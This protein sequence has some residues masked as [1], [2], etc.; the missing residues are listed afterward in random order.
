M[1]DNKLIDDLNSDNIPIFNVSEITNEIRD[2]LEN[3]YPYVKIKGEISGVTQAKSGHVYLKLKDEKNNIKGVIWAGIL[4]DLLIQPKD[5]DEVICSGRITTYTGYT[6]E[7]QLNIESIAYEGEGQLLKKKEEIK[8]KLEKEGLFDDKYKKEIPFIPKLLGIITSKSGAVLYEMEKIINE[9]FSV[10]RR[11]YPVTVQGKAAVREIVSA[12]KYFN[13]EKIEGVKADVLIIARGG[14]SIE[15]LWCFNDEELCRA[16]FD[17]K[18]PIISAIGH[19]PDTN[20]IDFVA[21]RRAATPSEAAVIVVPVRKELKDKLSKTF[22]IFKRSLSNFFKEKSMNLKQI[23]NNLLTPGQIYIQQKKEYIQIVKRFNNSVKVSI[24]SKDNELKN[25]S[26]VLE[27][28]S[29]KNILKRGYAYIKDLKRD[30][31][32]KSVNDIKDKTN[33]KIRFHDGTI[34]AITKKK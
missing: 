24:L 31:Y 7:Y 20:L 8:V 4:K 33:I 17:S 23:F 25:F 15:D 13:N 32:I 5:G 27:V 18:I 28:V 29:P 19:E 10:N 2:L 11:L 1:T 16:V 12:I 21:D 14:G 6:S 3:K 30:I 34:E 9:R 22:E 26:K